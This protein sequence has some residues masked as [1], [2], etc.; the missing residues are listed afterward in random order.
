MKNFLTLKHWQLF[1]L[2]FGIPF[3]FQ[4][5]TMGTII[6][7]RNPIE[8]M[9]YFPIMMIVVMVLFFSWFYTLGTNLHTKLPGTVSMNL[10]RFK[11]FLFI[12]LVYMIF[13]SVMLFNLF[14]NMTLLNANPKIAIFVLILIPVHLFS[15]FCIFYCLYFISKSL[16]SVELQKEVTFNDFSGEFFLFWF[17][18]IGVWFLQP[19]INK[20]FDSISDEENQ[21]KQKSI[22]EQ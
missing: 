18:L 17:F 10:T 7:Q 11:I 5:L 9:Q 19:R 16:K 8:F 6:S 2:L 13:L 3:I 22:F 20:L 1:I 15:M 4:S 14:S 12:P 21:S